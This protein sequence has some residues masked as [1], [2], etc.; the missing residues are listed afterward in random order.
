M[1]DP[2]IVAGH[3]H[4]GNLLEAIQSS[5]GK[6]GKTTSGL[7]IGDLAPVDEFHIGGRKA[8][9]QFMERLGFTRGL[10]LIDVGCGLGG[11]ARFAADTYGSQVTGID[12]TG[13]Y[14][15]TGNVMSGWTGMQDRVTLRK[16]SALSMS[17]ADGSFDGGYM[18]HVGMNIDD[19]RRLFAEIARVLKR[20]AAFGVYDVMRTGPGEPS[21]PV[22]WATDA[23]QSSLAAPAEYRAALE[24][25]GM[26]VL[27][28]VN[29]R[30]F[31]LEFFTTM[32]A[33]TQAAGGPPPLGL[34]TLIGETTQVKFR[35]MIDAISGN[36][37]APVE[38]IARKR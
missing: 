16:E 19:K 34:H 18:I 35:N 9:E 6:M 7:T 10:H 8:S 25:A 24:A 27:P 15:D 11:P 20:G 28:E 13:E 12:L 38:M 36:I 3:Y 21:Y 32:M 14:I 4:R 33:K 5:L 17:F 23:G 37:L 31:A 29:R 30:D 26:E 1:I 22:P 2:G